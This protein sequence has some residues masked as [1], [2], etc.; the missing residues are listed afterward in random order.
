MYKILLA[1][2]E[3][4]VLDSIRFILE[5]N[6]GEACELRTAKSGRMVIELSQEFA[7]DIAILD[8]QMPGINGIDAMKEIRTF[9]SRMVII[10]MSAYDKFVFAQEA[11][12]LGAIDYVTKPFTKERILEVMKKAMDIVD[13]ARKKRSNDLLVREKLQ[14]VV[15]IIEN[16][17]I[18]LVLFQEDFTAE[19]ESYRSLLDI[20]EEFG[21]MI[22]LQF[23]EQ[24]S[25]GNLE[26]PVG[27]SVQLQNYILAMREVIKEFFLHAVVGSIM[28]NKMI[29]FVPWKSSQMEFEE[30]SK[31]IERARNMVHKLG[32]QTS[33]NF[34]AGIGNVR[35]VTKL[36]DSYEESK[37]A[38]R[39]GRGSVVQAQD[40]MIGCDYE[41]DYPAETEEKL[42]LYVKNGNIEGTRESANLFFDWMI[43]NYGDYP[44]DIRTKVLEFVMTG[45]KEVFLQGGM[46]YGLLYRKDYLDTILSCATYEELRQWFVRKLVEA[47]KNVTEKKKEK[48]NSVVGKAKEYMRQ[49]FK[50]DIS[51]E[52]V[53]K[54]V[55]ISPY[56]FSKLFKEE[57]G[58]NFIDYLTS[59]RIERAKELLHDSEG[60]IKEICS[61]V[62]YSDPNYFSRIFKKVVGY[63]PTD[64]REGAGI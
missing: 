59:L 62:G 52:E 17:F 41:T 3:G 26:N 22:T 44:Q 29:I 24:D 49:N 35:N 38:L 10:V 45:E 7:P 12:N 50:R 19:M 33:L 30:R 64:Y 47:A 6:F 51:L 9:N 2:D 60:S 42:F 31:V 1:D 28:A 39:M 21:F 18:N 15:P 43:Q 20:R 25:S 36:H 13:D 58:E 53:A 14:T 34:R 5:K 55:D 46:R 8:I 4:I 16:G 27:T 54:F 32:Q 56:Y 11:M 61:E 63:T 23:G 40:L 37:K 48:N 57:E